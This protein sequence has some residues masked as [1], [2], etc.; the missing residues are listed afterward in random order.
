MCRLRTLPEVL[1]LALGSGQ[2]GSRAVGVYIETK[3]PAFHRSVGLPLEGKLVDAL[4]Q[5]GYREEPS[6]PVVL[7]S[8]EEQVHKSVAQT[9]CQPKFQVV[10]WDSSNASVTWLRYISNA[11]HSS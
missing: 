11:I 5:A 2:Q 9:F 6:A 1:G 4:V 3:D 8:F 7:Q 10:V